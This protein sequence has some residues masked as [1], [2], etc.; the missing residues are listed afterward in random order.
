MSEQ[1]TTHSEPRTNTKLTSSQEELIR[2][3]KPEVLQKHRPVPIGRTKPEGHFL[4]SPMDVRFKGT[5]A[6]YR[7]DPEVIK[8]EYKKCTGETKRIWT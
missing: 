7:V 2:P 4:K 3:S 8:E 5:C 1:K 6:T